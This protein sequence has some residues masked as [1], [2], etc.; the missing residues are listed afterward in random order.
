MQYLT[1]VFWIVVINYLWLKTDVFVEYAE[2]FKLKFLKYKEYREISILGNIGPKSYPEFLQFKW[3]NF[4]FKILNCNICLSV[5]LNL[6]FYIFWGLNFKY[7]GLTIFFSWI[8]YHFLQKFI[9]N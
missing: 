5:W 2:F 4:I 3:N 8:I 1:S 7:L 9:K 6:I